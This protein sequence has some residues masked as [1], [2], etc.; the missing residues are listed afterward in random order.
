MLQVVVRF[1]YGGYFASKDYLVR[2]GFLYNGHFAS[3][4]YLVGNWDRLRP[5]E[6]RVRTALSAGDVQRARDAL[7]QGFQDVVVGYCVNMLGDPVVGAE[8]AQ[9]VFIAA[10][11]ALPGFRGDSQVLTWVFRIARNKCLSHR[12]RGGRIAAIVA[13]NKDAIRTSAHPNPPDSPEDQLVKTE[14]EALEKQ[15]LEDSLRKLHKRER[16]L[17]MMRYYEGLSLVELAKRFWVG[18]TTV[19]RRLKNAEDH[20]KK[21]MGLSDHE[22]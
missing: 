20:L 22:A 14:A 12:G 19:R 1:S 7:V 11:Q 9:E 5:W 15:R 8:V 3:K 21:L 17:L 2:R 16:D 18:E 13:H 10:C 6:D 4:D